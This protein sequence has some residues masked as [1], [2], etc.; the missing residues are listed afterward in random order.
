MLNRERA[1]YRCALISV[2]SVLSLAIT[3]AAFGDP[4]VPDFVALPTQ[5][6]DSQTGSGT[7][8]PLT[9][10]IADFTRDGDLDLA[11][12]VGET[13]RD[14]YIFSGDGFGVFDFSSRFNAVLTA[15]ASV[16]ALV[17]SNNTPDLVT[18]AVFSGDDIGVTLNLGD[19]SFSD[20]SYSGS[21]PA[22]TKDLAVADLDGDGFLDAV[23]GS[24]SGILVFWGDGVGTFANMPLIIG[25]T[26]NVQHVELADLNGDDLLDIVAAPG[27]FGGSNSPIQIAL[28]SL[29]GFPSQTTAI[30]ASNSRASR[31]MSVG[32]LNGDSVP[33]IAVRSSSL[34]V[35]INDGTASFSELQGPTGSGGVTVDGDDLKIGD[36]NGDDTND[37]VLVDTIFGEVE[38]VLNDGSGTWSNASVTNFNAPQPI[39]LRLA[40][41]DNDSDLDI[42]TLSGTDESF[43]VFLNQTSPDE[44]GDF[45]L[46]TPFDADPEISSDPYFTWQ[47]APGAAV[48]YTLQISTD[49]GFKN[50][51]ATVVN[52]SGLTSP[53]YQLTSPTLA[54]LTDHYWRVTAVN[55]V[56]ST[57]SSGSFMFSTPPTPP[58][59]GDLNGDG[60]VDSSDLGLLLGAFGDGCP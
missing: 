6:I 13:E 36:L 7:V 39:E 55:D 25:D 46:Q 14:G 28:N 18:D 60:C 34:F 17:D 56:G 58:I 9:F 53:F 50:P 48:T 19:G 32:D 24:T 43:S 35:Y 11:I 8:E 4:A 12:F 15:S 16:A 10:D 22:I 30:S 49:P 51:G 52:E 5:P 59:I 45:V 20:V 21:A 38:F 40:D 47:P 29:I 26:G 57:L 2:T 23:T 44:P 27:G 41:V 37:I 31:S 33:D 42:V 54:G 1:G 3:P